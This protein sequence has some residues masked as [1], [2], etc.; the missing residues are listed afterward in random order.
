MTD[1][2]PE[3]FAGLTPHSAPPELRS[4]VLVAVERELARRKKPLWER[5]LELSVAAC[6]VLGVGLNVWQW[7]ADADWQQ[8]VFGSPVQSAR[9]QSHD[10]TLAASDEDVEQLIRN[11]LVM[12]APRRPV[13]APL[14][15][16]YERLLKEL[17]ESNSG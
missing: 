15:E 14:A 17:T 7:R 1:Q 10:R 5:A 13:Q 16:E 3:I 6:L 8:R 2:L 11:R 4:R 12:L 9:S